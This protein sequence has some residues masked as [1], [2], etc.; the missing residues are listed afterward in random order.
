MYQT[1]R[2]IVGLLAAS[3][4]LTASIPAQAT[5]EALGVYEDW[6]TPTMRA[7]RW[8]GRADDS[9]EVQRE[10]KAHRHTLVMRYRRLGQ[11]LPGIGQILPAHRIFLS[12]SSVIDH[13]EADFN[14]RHVEVVGCPDNPGRTR[15]RPAIIDFKA[16]NDGTPGEAGDQTGDHFIRV[17]VNQEPNA[18]NPRELAVQAFLFRCSD[19]ACANAV[20]TVFDLA[21][22]TVIVGRDFTLRARWDRAGS[23]FFVGLD[24]NPEAIL[25]YSPLLDGANARVPFASVR[26]QMIVGDCIA[27]QTVADGKAEVKQVRTNISAIVP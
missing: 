11:N 26:Q 4:I 16:F 13:L 3:I 14:V 7:D 6:T 9:Q 22:G 18:L 10:I 27:V 25:L 19:P 12:N 20:A 5:H 21:V 1:H 17:L 15:V 23:R 8:L 24:D 2:W